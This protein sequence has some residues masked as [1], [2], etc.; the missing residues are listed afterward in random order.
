[1]WEAFAHAAKTS[2]QSDPQLSQYASEAALDSITSSLSKD[3]NAG[4][5]TKGPLSVDPRVTAARPKTMP[6]EVDVVDCLDATHWLKYKR[7]GGLADKTPGGRHKVTAVV[8]DVGGWKV[9]S[10]AARSAGSC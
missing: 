6:S 1:M 8:K 5:V 7:S 9:T 10:F 2:N 4:L 3:R